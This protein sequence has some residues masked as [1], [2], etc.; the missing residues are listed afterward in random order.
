MRRHHLCA[1]QQEICNGFQRTYHK[2]S[3]LDGGVGSGRGGG[4]ATHARPLVDGAANRVRHQRL[5]A[6]LALHQ[7][8]GSAAREH[9][10][11]KKLDSQAEIWPWQCK[12]KKLYAVRQPLEL[13][14]CDPVSMSVII[15]Q[16]AIDL[17]CNMS[18]RHPHAHHLLRLNRMLAGRAQLQQDWIHFSL[19]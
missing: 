19:A 14:G 5:C 16:W 11:R 18:H 3:V 7:P 8:R 13:E 1:G 4:K 6:R 9:A 15:W 12:G 2:C 10:W 17:R